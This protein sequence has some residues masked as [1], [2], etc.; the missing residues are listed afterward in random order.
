MEEYNRNEAVNRQF[1]DHRVKRPTR[2]VKRYT[3]TR[4]VG[5][6][7]RV[8]LIIKLP[9]YRYFMIISLLFITNQYVDQLYSSPKLPTLIV[10]CF[11]RPVDRSYKSCVL[12]HAPCW[13]LHAPCWSLHAPCWSL[14]AL[15]LL[16]IKLPIYKL[17]M[18]YIL[19]VPSHL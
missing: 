3:F 15:N 2:R 1:Y 5:R 19:P 13:S 12:L 7:S 10:Y 11:M 8:V 18:I 6:N 9:N 14:H 16:I 17:V 4:L